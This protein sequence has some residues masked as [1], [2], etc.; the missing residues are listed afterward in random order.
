MRHNNT[1]TSGGK[2]EKARSENAR[3]ETDWHAQPSPRFRLR[4]LVQR[5]SVLRSQGSSSGPLRNAA[6]AHHGRSLDRRC[7]Y[8]VRCFTPHRLSGSGG[9]PAS[10]PERFAAK[11]P[12]SQSKTQAVFRGHRACAGVASGRA[13]LDDHRLCPSHSGKVR[14]HGSPPEPGTG[15]GEQKKTAQSGVRLPEETVE[16]YEALR[17][18]VIHRDGRGHHLE[19]CGVFRRCGL[20][21]WAQARPLPV[22]ARTPE[23]H[24]ESASESPVLDSLGT[25]LVRL[26]AGLILSIQQEVFLHA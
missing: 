10:W 22:A 12:W 25:E 3:V 1:Y 8:E 15:V 26:V 19:S 21:V 13:G 23:P 6:S 17:R 14:D 4:H 5:K 2:T 9:I 7:R 24:F 18:Q 16:A 11:T 20:A